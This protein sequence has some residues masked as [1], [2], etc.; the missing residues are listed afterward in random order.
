M[1]CKN[2]KERSL[3]NYMNDVRK[4]V[5]GTGTHRVYPCWEEMVNNHSHPIVRGL[6]D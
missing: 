1:H 5:K 6:L 4:A 3:G 2:E